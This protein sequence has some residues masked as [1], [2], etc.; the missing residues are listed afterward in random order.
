[1]IPVQNDLRLIRGPAEESHVPRLQDVRVLE[2][3]R[4]E[5]ASHEDPPG[6]GFYPALKNRPYI[7]VTDEGVDDPPDGPDESY[8]ASEIDTGTKWLD[9]KNIHRITFAAASVTPGETGAVLGNVLHDTLVQ[10]RGY[11]NMAS[12]GTGNWVEIGG[13]GFFMTLKDDGDLVLIGPAGV[14]LHKIHV[15]LWYTK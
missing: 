6:S 13:S 11:G 12:D 5:L 1:M 7:L 2:L 15:T 4:A 9:G 10:A 14:A 3:T 8:A